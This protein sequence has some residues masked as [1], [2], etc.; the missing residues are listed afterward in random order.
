MQCAFFGF[1]DELL[2]FNA[3]KSVIT[4]KVKKKL[5]IFFPNFVFGLRGNRS[6]PA[7][8]CCFKTEI[9]WCEKKY[10]HIIKH[11]TYNNKQFFEDH[12]FSETSMITLNPV[13]ISGHV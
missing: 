13:K 7:Q 9:R 6:G 11:I 10:L 4:W 12:T 1:L 5:Q 3:D 2:P 8:H